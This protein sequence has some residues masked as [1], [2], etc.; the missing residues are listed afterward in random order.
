MHAETANQQLSATYIRNNFKPPE[1]NPGDSVILFD[2]QSHLAKNVRNLVMPHEN[3]QSFP[4]PQP[5]WSTG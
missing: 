2:R 5:S 4:L 1:R 3:S